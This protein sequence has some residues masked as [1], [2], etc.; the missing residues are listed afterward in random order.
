[1][2]ENNKIM[3]Y[4]KRVSRKFDKYFKDKKGSEV[5]R[6]KIKYGSEV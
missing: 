1:M 6:Q 3:I 4:L 5:D 2:T